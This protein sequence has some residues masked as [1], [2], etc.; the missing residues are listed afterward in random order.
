MEVRIGRSLARCQCE[1]LVTQAEDEVHVH[2]HWSGEV[3]KRNRNSGCHPNLIHWLK[4]LR[5]T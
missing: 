1:E 3:Q 2:V 5:V 4:K